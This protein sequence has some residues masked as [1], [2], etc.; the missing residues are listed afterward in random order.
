MGALNSFKAI[1][2]VMLFYSFVIT[3]MTYVTPE[4]ALNYIESID[5]IT[6][7]TDLQEV[8]EKVQS[9]VEKQTNI[10]VVEMGALVFYSGNI[11]IDLIL[12]FIYAIPQ[13]IGLLVNLL[14]MLFNVESQVFA[15]VE[16]FAA[17]IYTV[18]MLLTLL[19][20]LTNIRAQGNVV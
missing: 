9:S 6:T 8:G 16:I 14:L 15:I 19:E 5:D 10:P 3:T 1:L 4:G 13:M 20:M 2:I 12:N 18:L 7:P 17:V 11:L